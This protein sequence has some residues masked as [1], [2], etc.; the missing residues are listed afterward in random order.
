MKKIYKVMSTM[1]LAA[2]I[3]GGTALGTAQAASPS[4]TKDKPT[5]GNS[6]QSKSKTASVTQD[7]IT[8]GL[9]KALYDGNYVSIQVERSGKGLIGGMIGGKWDDK[10]SE[11][12]QEKG[13]INKIDVFINGKSLYEYGDRMAERPS[14]SMTPGADANHAFIILSDASQLGGNLETFP[15]KFKITAKISL[16][17][18]DNP[19]NLEIP[20]QKTADKPVALQPNLTK[21][22]NGLS[23][24]LKN[25]K[26]TS[27]STRLQMV[28]KGQKEDSTI[29]Y[30][31]VDDQGNILD[32]ITGIGTDENN[33]NG[34]FYYD[35][36]VAALIK[37]A[38][39]ITI[40]PFTPEF[41]EPNAKHGA[42]KVDSN[43]EVVKNY[44]EELEMT[45]P[46]K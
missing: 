25:V 21:K 44:I 41:E 12:V 42:F 46:V 5:A 11:F 35:F 9:S 14:L 3:L 8:L 36:I 39:S 22:W 30:E 20:V 40:K 27:S 19:Y 23:M 17:G 7:G 1:A 10:A 2:M 45:V 31:F 13:M 15:D 33:A 16:E 24:T 37:D 6:A 29:L 43:G 38:K 34:D 18:V 4:A 26:V 32:P 28:L